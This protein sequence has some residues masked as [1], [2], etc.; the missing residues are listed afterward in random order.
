MPASKVGVR[1]RFKVDRANEIAARNHVLETEAQKAV[2]FGVT[3]SNWSRATGRDPDRAT[4]PGA[5]F[6]AAVLSS[7]AAVDY[8]NDVTFEGLFEVVPA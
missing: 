6:I 2:Y 3:P 5:L 8:P 7:P 1:V 4:D